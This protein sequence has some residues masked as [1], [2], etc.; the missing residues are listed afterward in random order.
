MG[1][2]RASATQSF[3]QV[4]QQ[5]ETIENAPNQDRFARAMKLAS[6]GLGLGTPRRPC[7]RSSGFGLIHGAK[8]ASNS[9]GSPQGKQRGGTIRKTPTGSIGHNQPRWPSPAVG[10][11][12]QR[13]LAGNQQPDQP[14]HRAG[15]RQPSKANVPV[16]GL[17]AALPPA[18]GGPPPT[19][20]PPPRGCHPWTDR[21]SA[22]E[23]EVP[24]RHRSQG[25]GP[26]S[27]VLRDR[28][29]APVRAAIHSINSGGLGH[30]LQ[31]PDR[32]GRPL[33]PWFAS[34]RRPSSALGE[35]CGTPPVQRGDRN[36]SRGFP[37]A[38]SGN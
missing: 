29:E 18:G 22:P 26:C 38:R 1:G 16:G 13:N 24:Y 28:P 2:S 4:T 15:A 9:P 34:K 25:T 12:E 11:P 36:S 19:P 8:A 7:W 33:H 35:V 10:A 5:Q 31:S 20:P 17:P 37:G 23:A 6:V 27:P 3:R 30:N 21:G 14:V 32:L